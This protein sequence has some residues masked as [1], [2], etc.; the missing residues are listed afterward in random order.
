MVASPCTQLASGGPKQHTI[1]AH[2]TIL[3]RDTIVKNTKILR[4]IPIRPSVVEA[5]LVRKMQPSINKQLASTHRTLK[6]CHQLIVPSH[7]IIF[8]KSAKL[9]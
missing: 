6:L 1:D 2:K 5:L 7:I 8:K 3:N 9:R 4:I